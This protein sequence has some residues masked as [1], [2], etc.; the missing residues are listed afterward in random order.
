ME[1]RIRISRHLVMLNSASALLTKLVGLSVLIWVLQFLLARIPAEEYAIYPVV[2][3]VMLFVPMLT[4]LLTG[5]AARHVLAAAA[6]GE[7]D[8]ITEIISST[9][10]LLIIAGLV[11]GGFGSMFAW[12]IERFLTIDP[13]YL[14]AAQQMMLWL[15]GTAMLRVCLVPFTL[16]LHVQQRFV[17]MNVVQ[18]GQELLRLGL[19]LTF[20]ALY[21]VS[22]LW[23]VVATCIAETLAMLLLVALSRAS[24]E[25]LR[26]RPSKFSAA[27]ARRMVSFGAWTSL[28]NLSYM[29]QSAAPAL[30]LNAWSSSTQVTT[31]HLGSIASRQANQIISLGFAPAQPALTALHATGQTT[32]LRRAYLRAGRWFLWLTMLGAVPLAVFAEPVMRLYTNGVYM[33]AAPVMVC[34]LA[35]FPMTYACGLLYRTALATGQVAWF[36]STALLAQLL[37]LGGMAWW[38]SQHDGDAMAV[39]VVVAVTAAITHLFVFWPLGMRLVG[40][41]WSDFW[42]ETLRP[43]LV[44]ALG[45][46]AM[47]LALGALTKPTSWTMVL[48]Y[49]AIVGAVQVGLLLGLCLLRND[50]IIIAKLRRRLVALWRSDQEA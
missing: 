2:T 33:D 22:V 38:V 20:F 16:G 34:L 13:A 48:A 21:G 19:L 7:D 3:A 9:T 31:W 12:Q 14:D 27:T 47:A 29:L 28:G 45:G 11:I 4:E 46:C 32:R 44:P 39:A 6:R 18:L 17:V 26:F 49:S 41:R 25:S 50:R 37:A 1:S 23:L 42:R 43:G 8:R 24:L 40:A 30:V 10:P 15:V 5:G 35:L 36:F